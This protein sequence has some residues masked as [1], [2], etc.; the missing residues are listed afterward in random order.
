MQLKYLMG[1]II[2]SL[3][4]LGL[5]SCGDDDNYLPI[6]LS[7][8]EENISPIGNDNTLILS[9]FDE[10]GYSFRI[11]GGNG[12][13]MFDCSDNNIMDFH[14]DGRTLTISPKGLGETVFTITDNAGN[15]YTLNVTVTYPTDTYKIN[16]ITAEI[17]GG[18]LTLNAY[19]EIKNKIINTS[20]MQPGGEYILTYMNKEL[21]EGRIT[22]RQSATALPYEGIFKKVKGNQESNSPYTQITANMTNGEEHVYILAPASGDNAETN[23]STT[24]KEE[25]TNTYVGE[26][27][28]LEKAYC[29][30]IVSND[31]GK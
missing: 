12:I 1:G 2:F 17:E 10:N 9:P 13:Y 24:I 23:P 31:N 27:P 14:H 26:Y 29:V 7:C 25:V 16:N 19:E 15:Y 22:L 11:T 18:G 6:S 20:L 8:T 28:M 5:S 3:Y 21:T 4:T 30:H